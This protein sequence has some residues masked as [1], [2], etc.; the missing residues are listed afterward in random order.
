MNFCFILGNPRSGTSLFRLMLNAHPQIV[1]PPECGFIQWNFS[2]FNK[3][4]FTITKNRNSFAQAVLDSKKMETWGLTMD[5]LTEAFNEVAVPNYQSLVKAVFCAYSKSKGNT[6]QPMVAVDKNNYYLNFLEEISSAMPNA[7]YIHLVRDVRDVANSYL[8]I[9]KKNL[10]GKYV[11]NLETS[12][13][14]IAGKWIE[15]NE[16]LLNFL[17]D[18]PN[19]VLRYE[20]LLIRPQA[21]LEKVALFLELSY[22]ERMNLFYHHNDEPQEMLNWKEK[23]LQ[24]I[25]P[26]RAGAFRKELDSHFSDQLWNLAHSSLNKFGYSK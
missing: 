16:R 26:G 14:E 17:D 3:L 11:P 21:E 25:D 10:K 6:T 9:E 2:A 1:A 18:K 4:D 7:K 5:E 23:T 20:D 19:L 24:P 15:N 8:E 13:E 12:A 22:H